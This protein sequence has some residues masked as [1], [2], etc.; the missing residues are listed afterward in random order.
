MSTDSTTPAGGSEGAGYNVTDSERHIPI[1]HDTHAAPIH[2]PH[3]PHLSLPHISLPHLHGSA[4]HQPVA[5]VVHKKPVVKSTHLSDV[6]MMG[7]TSLIPEHWVCPA[8]YVIHSKYRHIH[9]SIFFT[10]IIN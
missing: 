9:V 3:L 10:K 4:D 7:N 8:H 2:Q 1:P 5:I 6:F